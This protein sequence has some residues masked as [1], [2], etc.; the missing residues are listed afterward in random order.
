MYVTENSVQLRSTARPSVLTVYL[1]Y[2]TN[3]HDFVA[4]EPLSGI[5]SVL[6]GYEYFRINFDFPH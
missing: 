6:R 4:S 5:N 2:T 1:T 3:S